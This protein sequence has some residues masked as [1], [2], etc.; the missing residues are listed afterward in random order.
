[1]IAHSIIQKSQLEGA[2]RID[3]EY[4][5][6]EYLEVERKL[7]QIDTVVMNDISESVVNFGAYSLCNYIEWQEE[8]VPYLNVE[9]IKEGLIDY[10]GVKY[11]GEKVNEILKKSKVK[12]GQVIITMAGT[13]GNAAVAHKVPQKINSNQATAKITLKKGFSPYYL[14]AFLNCYYGRAQTEREIVSSVQPNIFLWQ[15]K[16]FK[17]PALSSVKQKGIE[18]VYLMAL[19]EFEMSQSLYSQA[20]DMLLEWLG[21]KDFETEDE[22]YSVVNISDIKSAKRID[23]EYFQGKYESLLKRIKKFNSKRLLELTKRINSRIKIIPD[24]T[25]KY[26]EI[27][28]VNTATGDAS[29]NEILGKELPAS[30]Q[31]PL[32]GGELIV[33]KVRPTRGAISIIPKTY[34]ED[35]V[36]S[37]AFSV[38]KIADVLKEY[39][40]VL[41][42]S[43]IG[44]LQFEKP[45]TGTSYPT[46]TDEDIENVLV[47]ILP[48]P[49]QQ[50]IAALVRKSH[51]ARKKAKQL[52]E[53]AKRKVE[54]EIEKAAGRKK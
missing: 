3:A 54:E 22:L 31:I 52:L 21:L 32:Q 51:E 20:E 27:S 1:M 34:S 29:F 30:A 8:G 7:H 19:D 5:Q 39:L 15:I 4:F 45:T 48:K 40:F 44:R 23:A 38:Y 12:E 14:S 53:E 2:K 43:I 49:K 6:P 35:F 37:S 46:I 25:Y 16:S 9:N 18:K 41:L 11:I 24:S 33:S 26:I 42:R 28:D 10:E 17:V 47:P 36:C 13:I 50:N